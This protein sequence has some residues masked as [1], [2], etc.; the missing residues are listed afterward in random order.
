M[1]NQITF[2]LINLFGFT[3]ISAQL[4]DVEGNVRI[5]NTVELF[6]RSSG[7][8]VKVGTLFATF[9]AGASSV[10]S[11]T[12]TLRNETSPIPS[13]GFGDIIL[14]SADQIFLNTNTST[15]LH[16]GASG[17]VGIGTTSPDDLFHVNG[18]AIF[19]AAGDA[20][21]SAE[22]LRIRALNDTWYIGVQNESSVGA[23][24][25][26]IGKS[27]VE[28]G[29]FHIQNNGNIGIG[30]SSPPTKFSVE[31]GGTNPMRLTTSQTDNY[32]T[33]FTSNGYIGYQGVFN[34][35]LDMDFGTGASNNTGKVHLVTSAS[36]RLTVAANG[37]VGVGTTS[38]AAELH[39]SG[40]NLSAELLIEAD[41]DNAGGE[42]DHPKLT[43]SQDGGAVTGELGYYNSTN[44]LRIRNNFGGA[45]II[46]KANGDI[47]IGN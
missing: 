16:V 19:G 13:N 12:L 3:M 37:D 18:D 21:A 6:D 29:T 43:L 7:T 14:E 22:I 38:P 33:F 25:F 11:P 10:N 35:N 2:I 5:D 39:V 26:F 17:R 31:S 46:L 41:V 40:G 44:D 23:T 20:E 1:K 45:S 15:R 8:P 28:D 42:G 30:T 34:G 24:D 36:P 4:A 47:I 32:A 9:P 27:G